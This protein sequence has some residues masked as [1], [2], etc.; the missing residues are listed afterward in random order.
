[1]ADFLCH[2]KDDRDLAVS[3]IEGYR[4]AIAGALR[5]E[6]RPDLGKDK[7]LSSL[8][9][10]MARDVPRRKVSAPRWDLSLVLRSLTQEPFEPLAEIPLKYLTWKTVFLVAFA[11]GKRRSELHALTSRYRR[12]EDWSEITLFTEA[13]F[14]AKTDLAASSAN[15][16]PLTIR[17]L[18]SFLGPGLEQ[19]GKLCPVRALKAYLERVQDIR[20]ERR[21]LFIAY[22][23][24][25]KKE[26]APNTLSHW[27]RNTILQAYAEC[28]EEDRRVLRVRAHDVRGMAA[29]WARCRQ[30][31]TEAIMA[32]CSWKAHNTFTHFYLKDLANIEDD[33]LCLG[34][35]VAAMQRV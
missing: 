10:N 18:S 4:T 35:V 9:A 28:S 17:A 23:Q 20:G 16:R 31:S 32:A 14:L 1:M 7:G 30:A 3:T 19:D 24:G 27:I 5:G 21:K 29:S 26:I 6:G 34:P 12:A 33:M 2:L 22:K 15:A 8:L 11:T 25:H 13:G